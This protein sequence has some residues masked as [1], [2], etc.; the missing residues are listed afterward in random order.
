MQF[1]S[2]S[3][4]AAAGTN[5]GTATQLYADNNFI[6]SGTGGVILPAATTGREVSVTNNTGAAIN[7]YPQ[8]THTIESGGAGVPTVLP[9]L[10]TISVMAKS[11]NNWWTIQP[12]YNPSNNI[13]ITQS[14][15][16]TVTWGLA[17][18]PSVTGITLATSGV[19]T[20]DFDN[21][22]FA[23]RTVFTTK[24]TNASTGIYAVPNGTNTA[25]SWQALNNSNPTN[26]SKILIATNGST[27]VQLVSGINGS[28][29]Y[30]PL[31]FYNNGVQ[32]MQLAVNGSLGFTNPTL[33]TSS[34]G[35]VS[36]FTTTTTA[37]TLGS[38]TAPVTAFAATAT[39]SSTSASLGYLGMPQQSKSGAY[40]TVIGD[41]GKHIYV[42][43]TATITIDSN[44][45]VAYPIGTTIAFIAGTGATVTI[46]ITSDTMYLGGT[47][48]TGSRTLAAY[49]M[50][51][52]VKVAATT[53]FINGTGLT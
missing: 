3:S 5:Q 17:T 48:T 36:L 27:D 28:G 43:A 12:V 8:G 50:A 52:A 16:G 4:V 11:G 7:V 14:A 29:T 44:A 1:S 42:T 26:A 47:G 18:T 21:A 34:T 19:F 15:N 6:T 25:A 13:T 53:W 10:A 39:T 35:T 2:A 32:Q 45:N 31:S 40:T 38:S 33:T 9:N 41:Q 20:G 46:A 22:T 51:T 24:T 37:I 49:G 30:L 23:N